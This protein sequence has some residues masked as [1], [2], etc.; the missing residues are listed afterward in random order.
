MA[1]SHGIP[2]RT[3]SGMT[4]E[5]DMLEACDMLHV[6]VT[7]TVSLDDPVVVD[8]RFAHDK[9]FEHYQQVNRDFWQHE[10]LPSLPARPS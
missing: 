2:T 8:C 10:N 4:H 3:L 5:P 7:A 1:A 6:R 9:I